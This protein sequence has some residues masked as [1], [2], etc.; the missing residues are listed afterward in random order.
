MSLH[1]LS[2][3]TAHDHSVWLIGSN[4][5]LQLCI[6]S[7]KRFIPIVKTQHRR[8]VGVAAN[9]TKP[10]RLHVTAPN[11]APMPAATAIESALQKVTRKTPF[12]MFA[13]P[14]LAAVHGSG[15]AQHRC[16]GALQTAGPAHERA[17][18]GLASVDRRNQ[19]GHGAAMRQKVRQGRCKAV[20]GWVVL[21]HRGVTRCSWRC[22][23]LKNN[24][25]RE[26]LLPV[27]LLHTNQM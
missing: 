24:C 12:L 5:L 2:R 10:F 4:S 17:Q 15:T 11:I 8:A 27:D 9:A 20:L 6:P 23:L 26:Q 3:H 1:L 22:W 19:R 25:H 7:P 13:P 21:A 16:Q 14:T 18:S